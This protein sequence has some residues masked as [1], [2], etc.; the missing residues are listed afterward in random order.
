MC[1]ERL[2]IKDQWLLQVTLP[3]W[4]LDMYIVYSIESGLLSATALYEIS[5]ISVTHPAGTTY[6]LHPVVVT[7][8]QEK[9]YKVNLPGYPRNSPWANAIH[10][11]FSD[12]HRCISVRALCI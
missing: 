11:K 4:P 9:M 10:G 3:Q 12:Q 7:Y 8:E 1:E 2:D 5:A 6:A